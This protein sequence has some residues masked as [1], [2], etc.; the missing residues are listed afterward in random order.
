MSNNCC[1]VCTLQILHKNGKDQCKYNVTCILLYNACQKERLIQGVPKRGT[2]DSRYFDIRNFFF[3][4]SHLR[5]LTNLREIFTAGGIPGKQHIGSQ[6]SHYPHWNVTRMKRKLTMTMF[7]EMTI[8]TKLLNQFHWSWY[9]SF[10]ETILF[11]LMKSKYA[12]FSKI[13]VTK[14]ERSA[15]GDTR[16]I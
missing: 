10:Q 14:I 2:L 5:I 3:L 12:I 13:K 8:E 6:K 15:F 1:V 16:Y 11:Y 7:W 9:H 4:H